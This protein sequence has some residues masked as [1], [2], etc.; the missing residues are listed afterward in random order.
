MQEK[1][2]ARRSIYS[3]PLILAMSITSP[4]PRAPYFPF[5]RTR[6]RLV[7][8]FSSA[9]R[10]PGNFGVLG[11]ICLGPTG[12]RTLEG[13]PVALVGLGLELGSIIVVS[14]GQSKFE[15]L[16]I[17]A[18]QLISESIKPLSAV[19]RTLSYLGCHRCR[20]RGPFVG[21]DDL[22]MHSI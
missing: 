22:L 12:T 6:A 4:V 15:I 21:S 19:M 13:D 18:N 7:V 9:C 10:F 8:G 3:R 1:L 16:R 14:K 20:V 11:T 2:P 17:L 5:R